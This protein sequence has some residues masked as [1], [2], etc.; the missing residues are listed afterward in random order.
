MSNILM[1]TAL[2]ALSFGTRAGPPPTAA[3][4]AATAEVI[5]LSTVH[6]LHATTPGYGF[7]DLARIVEALAPDVLCVELQAEDL[8]ARPPEPNKQEYPSAIYPLIDRHR[9]RVY[10][11]EPSEPRFGALLGPYLQASAAFAQAAPEARKAM[12]AYADG[13]YGALA[14]YWTSPVRVNDAV[15]DAV[16]GAKHDLQQ[17]LVGPGERA[18]WQAWNAHFLDVVVRAARENPGRR[19]VVTV[20]AEHGYWL[21]AHL[22]RTPGIVLRDAAAL[23]EA[24]PQATAGTPDPV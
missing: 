22:A 12:D 6:Q 13:V 7:A 23:L 3:P 2:L 14:R 11:L 19:V 20:G 16:L 5:V 4:D 9:Y 1:A 18:G 10:P 21:R 8:S 17:A 24:L 15:T